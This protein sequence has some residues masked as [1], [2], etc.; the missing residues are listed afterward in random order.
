MKILV[1]EDDKRLAATVKRGLE[2]EGYAVDVALDGTDGQWM[3][4][5]QR[6]DAIVL[7]VMLPGD[8]RLSLVRGSSRGRRLDTDL[9][10]HRQAR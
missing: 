10:A 8:Q 2:Q 4:T 3:A 6:Y 1:I 9:D 7:D 5:E